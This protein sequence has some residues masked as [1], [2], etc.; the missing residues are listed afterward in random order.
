MAATPHPAH[1]IRHLLLK[2]K[3]L[4]WARFSACTK[5][6]VPLIRLAIRSTPS[7]VWEK[8]FIVA[9]FHHAWPLYLTIADRYE[10]QMHPTTPPW[11]ADFNRRGLAKPDHRGNIQG[12]GWRLRR[13]GHAN[14]PCHGGGGAAVPP[15][16]FINLTFTSHTAFFD[17]FLGS[18][19]ESYFLVSRPYCA[20]TVS[21]TTGSSPALKA[22]RGS[23]KLTVPFAETVS[24]AFCAPTMV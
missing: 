13:S 8:A 4:G 20:E 22:E 18:K 7:P 2:E 19:K 23:S 5:R 10:Q 9:H 3:D 6:C 15:F 24:S 1:Y 21:S 16:S 11:H 14:F 12:D 17:S